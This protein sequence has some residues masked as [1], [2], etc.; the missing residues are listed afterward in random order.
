[1]HRVLSGTVREFNEHR[2]QCSYGKL[3]RRLLICL[4]THGRP[5]KWVYDRFI[6]SRSILVCRNIHFRRNLSIVRAYVMDTY[7]MNLNFT[8][9]RRDG[10]LLRRRSLYFHKCESWINDDRLY[11]LEKQIYAN[12]LNWLSLDSI[13]S[14]HLLSNFCLL[15]TYFLRDRA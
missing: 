12:L 5:F 1:M 2:F 11:I 6:A 7:I 8:V 4:G 10:K 9:G 3:V 15:A 14:L 13:C